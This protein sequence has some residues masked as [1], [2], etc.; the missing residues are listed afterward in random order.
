MAPGV[1]WNNLL[2]TQMHAL[3]FWQHEQTGENASDAC[4]TWLCWRT[5]LNAYVAPRAKAQPKVRR[6][7]YTDFSPAP[8]TAT[9]EM[10]ASWQ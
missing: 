2:C 7:V 3:A 8:R 4:R 6:G 10:Q 9:A 5:R 1:A